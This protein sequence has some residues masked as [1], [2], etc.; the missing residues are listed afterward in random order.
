ML[1]NC[2]TGRLS[3]VSA[4][5]ITNTMEITIATIG[6]L[7]KNFDMAL[8]AHRFRTEWFR[9]NL[10]T[11]ADFLNSFNNY[12]LTRVEAARDHPARIDLGTYCDGSD[13]HL[14]VAAH[15]AYLVATLQ[16]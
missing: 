10:R 8:P 15:N 11:S 12:A 4:P 7:I 3:T 5:M 16:L 14:V 13:G 2:A 9:V 6:R 1:G